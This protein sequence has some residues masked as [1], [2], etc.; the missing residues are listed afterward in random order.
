M[1]MNATRPEI[2]VWLQGRDITLALEPYLR[3]LTYVDHLEGDEPDA[4]E[5]E[6]ED[7]GRIFQGPRYPSRGD[8]IRFRFGMEGQTLFDSR[9]GFQIDEIEVE[10][11]PDVVVLR[12]VSSLPTSAIHDR[13]SRVWEGVTIEQIARAVA[14]KHNLKV[15]VDADQVSWTR[16]TQHDES[17][18]QFLK[19]LAREYGLLASIKARAPGQD[20]MDGPPLLVLHKSE[21][22]EGLQPVFEAFR[23]DVKK[24]HFRNKITAGERG[25]YTRWFDSSLKAL[26]EFEATPEHPARDLQGKSPRLTTRGRTESQGNA[27]VKARRPLRESKGDEQQATLTFPGNRLL[28]AGANLT[29]PVDEWSRLGGIYQILSSRHVMEVSGGYE[30]EATLRRVK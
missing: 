25:S 8:S 6:L 26:V 24:F 27:Q 5:I 20:E 11:P 30:V 7:R 2:Q 16:I 13:R 22:L 28:I 3:K 18:W 10:G 17:D 21:A 19:R 12:A 9:L 4:L 14:A 1:G 15:R 23:N 29:L